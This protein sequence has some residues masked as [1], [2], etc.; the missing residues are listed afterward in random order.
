MEGLLI[1]L[2]LGICLDTFMVETP[3]SHDY[4][5]FAVGQVRFH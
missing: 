1:P 5:D 2:S 3:T 4:D